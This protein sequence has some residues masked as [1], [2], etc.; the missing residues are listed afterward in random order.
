MIRPVSFLLHNL[1]YH[2]L[3][4]SVEEVSGSGMS[5]NGTASF[6]PTEKQQSVN[7]ISVFTQNVRTDLTKQLSAPSCRLPDPG[8]ESH[9]RS[10]STHQ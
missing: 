2:L 10:D 5:S 9:W 1:P 8:F 6:Q 7:F 4:W 3:V